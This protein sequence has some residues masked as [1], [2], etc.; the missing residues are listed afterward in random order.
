MRNS[1]G[2]TYSCHIVVYYWRAKGSG[3]GFVRLLRLNYCSFKYFMKESL[4]K[5]MN[6]PFFVFD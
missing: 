1:Y 4:H 5:I 2:H 6:S 3:S